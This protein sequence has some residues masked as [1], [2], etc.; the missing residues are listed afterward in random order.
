M[1][2]EDYSLYS[3]DSLRKFDQEIAQHIGLTEAIILS[4][5]DY[6][7]EIKQK[8]ENKEKYKDSFRDGK[9]WVYNS[10]HK[11]HTKQFPYFSES[12]IKRAVLH[13]EKLGILIVGTYNKMSQDKSKWYTIDYDRLS[14]IKESFSSGQIDPMDGS[15]WSD[16]RVKLTQA[17]PTTSQSISQNNSLLKVFNG[18]KLEKQFCPKT[19]QSIDYEILKRQIRSACKQEELDDEEEV[20]DIV[21]IIIYY[22]KA[23]HSSFGIYHPRV[24]QTVMRK[25]VL[26]IHYPDSEIVD[27]AD[28]DDYKEMIDKHFETRYDNCDYHISHFF[29]GRITENRFYETCYCG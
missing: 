10:Y 22:F 6:W 29:T 4:Q 13:L 20:N 12:T 23:Y 21:E 25:V 3:G 7:L 9:V 5:I 8:P 26:N 18:T 28:V 14:E 2:R 17:I 16:G 1:S 24:K 11:W 19:N 27:G 15:N